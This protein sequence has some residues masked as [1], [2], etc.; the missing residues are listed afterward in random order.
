MYKCLVLTES[1]REN[2]PTQVL[3]YYRGK[4]LSLF[5]WSPSRKRFWFFI[6]FRERFWDTKRNI[7]HF[8]WIFGQNSKTNGRLWEKFCSKS[9]KIVHLPFSTGFP[10]SLVKFFGEEFLLVKGK[11]LTFRTN[12]Y[13]W[14]EEIKVT[15]LFHY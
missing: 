6:K 10:I 12:I 8:W 13:P 14:K 3:P 7:I 1:K 11:I 15:R 2:S 5:P 4:Y 9:A